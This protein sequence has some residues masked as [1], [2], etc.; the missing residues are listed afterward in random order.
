MSKKPFSVQQAQ[1]VEPLDLGMSLPITFFSNQEIAPEWDAADRDAWLRKFWKMF[2][3]DMLQGVLAA[4]VAKVQ[5]QNWELEGPEGLVDLYHPIMRDDANFGKGYGDLVARGVVDYYTQDNGWFM[6]RQRSGAK[7][8]EGPMLGLAHLDSARMRPTGN[9]DYPYIYMDVYG[10]HHLMHR[11]QFIRIVDMPNPK[12][13]LHGWD[14]GFCALSRALSTALILTMLVTLKQEKLSDLPPSALAIFNNLTRKQFEKAISLYG[15]QEDMKNNTVWRSLMPL[16]GIDPAHPASVQFISLREVWESYDDMTAMNI[17][18]YSFAAAWRIDP[19]EFWP[20][21]QGPLGTGKEAEVQHQKAKAKSTGLLF[22]EIERAF[23][24]RESLPDGLTF[25]YALQDADEEQQ[26][27]AIH[28]LQIGNV[29][30][31]QEAGASLTPDE[32]RWILSTQ[33]RIL[34]RELAKVPAEGEEFNLVNA[35]MYLDDVER[36][37][38]EYHGWYWGPCVRMDAYGK[39][40]M[41]SP[42]GSRLPTGIMY[43][44][45]KGGPGSG[46]WGHAGRPGMVGGSAKRGGGIAGV[47]LVDRASEVMQ[48]DGG[49]LRYYIMPDGKLADVSGTDDGASECTHAEYAARFPG[50]FG[51]DKKPMTLEEIWQTHTGLSVEV[52]KE[53]LQDVNDAGAITVLQY[54]NQIGLAGNLPITTPNLRK[55]HS[56]LDKGKLP[57][58]RNSTY[59]W[60]DM[61]SGKSVTVSYDDL[62]TSRNVRDLQVLSKELN[63]NLVFGSKE[64]LTDGLKGQFTCCES[65]AAQMF[66]DIVNDL[67]ELGYLS[68]EEACKASMAPSAWVYGVAGAIAPATAGKR[69]VLLAAAEEISRCLGEVEFALG[70]KE[71]KGLQTINQKIASLPA[72]IARTVRDNAKRLQGAMN[73]TTKR[74][75]NALKAIPDEL[76]DEWVAEDELAE[77]IGT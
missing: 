36:Q 61:S 62:I 31:M 46:N 27:A 40:E 29:K 25:K 39:K 75:Q 68:V 47:T 2:G 73:S 17:A 60:Q 18:A 59:A 51:I 66:P 11:S 44:G 48:D 56:W 53:Y 54:G 65:H 35:R 7:D 58:R 12:T 43:L 16:F 38:K 14:K 8:H 76:W 22:T 42:G 10:E 37:A 71:S 41:A 3:N 32:V 13:E 23:N 49:S 15:A 67:F 52:A 55:I 4:S 28:Q 33:Y 74:R 69:D 6:E 77:Q 70:E 5:T 30:T 64:A 34:P 9:A 21:S 20:V 19:R 24:A 72:P 26:R 57:V 1:N 63:D 50:L 45:E